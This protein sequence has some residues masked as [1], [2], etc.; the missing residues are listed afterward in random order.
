M[1][2]L[3]LS[4]GVCDAGAI[5]WCCPLVL[6]LML[7]QALVSNEVDSRGTATGLLVGLFIALP[8]G[9]TRPTLLLALLLLLTL[10]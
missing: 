7:L 1:L 6:V 3:V 4:T 2:I 10:L 9:A 8:A 5:H